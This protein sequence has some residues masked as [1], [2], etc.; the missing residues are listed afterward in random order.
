MIPPAPSLPRGELIELVR[1][2]W[3]DGERAPELIRG[4]YVGRDAT[5]ILITDGSRWIFLDRAEWMVCEA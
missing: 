5:R 1:W 2:S 3:V 4:N